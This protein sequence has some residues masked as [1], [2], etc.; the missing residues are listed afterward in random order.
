MP[1]NIGGQ[2]DNTNGA[3]G[4]G[5]TYKKRKCKECNIAGGRGGAL[6]S[7]QLHA[8]CVAV[9]EKK[10]KAKKDNGGFA[11]IWVPDAPRKRKRDDH[12]NDTDS[13][14]GGG[15]SSRLALVA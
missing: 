12:N 13:G 15:G 6:N 2:A 8:K 5:T 4:A 7:D 1:R 9:F 14:G 10:Q 3:G 11:P